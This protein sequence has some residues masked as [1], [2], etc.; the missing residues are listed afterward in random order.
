ML[1]TFKRLG[2]WRGQRFIYSVNHGGQPKLIISFI[3]LRLSVAW[4]KE[5]FAQRHGQYTFL[6]KEWSHNLC[7]TFTLS[8]SL[9]A[10]N[11][12][13]DNFSSERKLRNTAE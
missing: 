6:M 10:F 1:K 8:A 5:E 7:E 13:G 4:K 9:F 3:S 12:M 11:V 2:P